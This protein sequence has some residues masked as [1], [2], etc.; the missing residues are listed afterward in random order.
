MREYS[1]RNDGV[2]YTENNPD[3]NGRVVFSD[4]STAILRGGRGT[5]DEIIKMQE[6]LSLK[7]H[8]Q[9]HE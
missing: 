2:S 1:L 9:Q 8:K 7:W 4:I 5:V 3:Y 6:R